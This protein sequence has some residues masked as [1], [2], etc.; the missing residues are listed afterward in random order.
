MPVEWTITGQTGKTVDAS[1]HT[2]AD[3]HAE[4]AVVSFQ[5]LA[6]DTLEWG[7]WLSSLGDAAGTLLPDLGQRITL[8]RNG[9]RFFTGIV[10]ARDPD[11]SAGNYGW[12]IK[13]SGPWWWLQQLLL[14]SEMEDQAGNEEER[15]V[16]VFPTG[17][18][19]THLIAL[20]ARA[21]EQGAPISE[22][23]I[24]SA[25]AV[26]RLSLRDMPIGEAVASVMRWLADGIVYFDYATVGHPALCMQRRVAAETLTIT[27]A[28][29]M[30]RLRVSPRLDLK[31]EEVKVYSAKRE[32]VGMVRKAVWA[33][34]KAGVPSSGLPVRQPVVVS[35]PEKVWDVLPQDFTDS[36][37]VRSAPALS[38]GQVPIEMLWRYDERLRASGAVPVFTRVGL[39]EELDFHFGYKFGLSGIDTRITD[40]EGNEIPLAY[41]HYLTSG[42]PRDWWTKDGIE[43]VMARVT[44]TISTYTITGQ[45]EVPEPPKWYELMGGTYQSYLITNSPPPAR[46]KH[47]WSTTVSVS[48]PFVKT[49]WTADTVLIRAEDYAF[50][51]P[52]PG[53][54][55]NLLATQDWLPY[56]GSVSYVTAEIPAGHHLGKRLNVSGTLPELA[57]MG[58]LVSGH[59]I[60]LATGEHTLQLGAPE[61]LGYKDLVARFRQSGADNIVWLVDQVSSD[62]GSNPPPD[63]ELEIPTGPPN[64]ILY[65]GQPLM[66][67]GEY[68]V[69]TAGEAI[70]YEGNRLLYEGRVLRYPIT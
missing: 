49:A 41:S 6:A 19:R 25:F 51:Q 21:I 40:A 30:P 67:D 15:S 39:W 2:L 36:V 1:A 17:S 26:P 68:L 14:S 7:V 61:R 22:G 58:A 43:H 48:V 8:L 47:V 29:V 32:T 4:G 20:I 52:P 9:I 16:F 5:S 37:T 23:T 27:P 45:T 31:A 34:Q 56:E 66:W 69:W 63:P 62:P 24:A 60:R 18:P 59:T 50:V 65:N 3:L 38:A 44:A 12:R 55:A 57:N 28:A 70:T 53:L 54:A 13:V 42:E 35:G 11:L 33:E 46:L 10:I 64:A